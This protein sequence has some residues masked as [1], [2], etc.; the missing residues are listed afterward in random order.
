MVWALARSDASSRRQAEAPPYGLIDRPAGQPREI[1]SAEEA[2]R[3]Q[4]VA[5]T[6]NPGGPS[7]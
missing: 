1:Q 4:G 6:L 2:R 3:L 5:S 7:S